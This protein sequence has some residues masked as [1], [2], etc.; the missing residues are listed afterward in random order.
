MD[1]GACKQRKN[2]SMKIVLT[3]DDGFN[4]PGLIEL[5]KQ[6]KPMGEIMIV[7]PKN[8][9]S[10]AGHRVTLKEPIPV[11]RVSE[12][13]YIVDGSPADCTRLALK[14][15]M[16]DAHWV[17]AGINP[18]ANLGTD[19]YQSGT[20]AAAREAAILG[21]KAV[22]VS[23]YIAPNQKI[24]WEITGQHVARILS[25]IMGKKLDSGNFWNI[26][27]PHPIHDLSILEYNECDLDKKPHLF[28]FKIEN[29]QY[30]YSGIF[31]NRPRTQGRDID[32]CL[33]GKIAV[34]KIEI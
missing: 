34:S 23:Q 2:G 27:L 32:I 26:N 14:K 24:D 10:I 31:H 8:P 5:A 28:D 4:E 3:N 17:I 11:E 20:V 30:R 18:G 25:I 33:S 19:V 9:Q 29:G 15:F 13:E 7:A 6:V 22:A 16:P 21:C 12:N 1:Q